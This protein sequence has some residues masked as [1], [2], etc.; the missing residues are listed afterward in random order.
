MPTGVPAAFFSYCREDSEFAL[1]LAEDLK[2]AGANVWMDQLDIAPGQRW[3]R[4]VEDALTNCPRLLVILSPTSVNSTNVLDE[5][6]FA[7]ENQK[8]VIPVLYRDC[9]IPFRL[10]RIQYLDFRADYARAL[11]S[12]LK[13]LGVEQPP[14]GSVVAPYP[15][16]AVKQPEISTVDER[17]AEARL[18]EEGKQAAK[19]ARLEQE[20]EGTEKRDRKADHEHCV[21]AEQHRRFEQEGTESPA[22]WRVEFLF[23]R[24]VWG[25]VVIALC[26]ILIIVSV[27][28]WVRR[29]LVTLQPGTWAVGFNGT[30]LHRGTAGAHG[31]SKAAALELLCFLSPLLHR[32]WAGW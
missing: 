31:I 2:A 12:L 16:L 9:A 32:S 17:A 8:T 10:R 14:E 30:I 15:P 13:T 1:R 20:R 18:E 4:S 25:R 24:S 21:S 6:S 7:L 29:Y 28:Y 11:K 26:G 27:L 23:K 22:G 19:Q 5:V 3:D